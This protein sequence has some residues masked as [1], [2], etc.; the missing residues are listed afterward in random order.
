M[1]NWLGTWITIGMAV[2]LVVG[3]SA[4]ARAGVSGELVVDGKPIKIAT[5]YAYAVKGTFDP[6][7]QDVVV[8]LCD[9]AVP[10]AAQRDADARIKISKEGK[11][12]CVEQTIEADKTVLG[13]AVLHERF[14][15]FLRGS[16]SYHK[17]EA[18]TF[19]GKTVAGHSRTSRPE[20]FGNVPYSYDITFSVPIAPLK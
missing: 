9:V 14:E 7:A 3:P 4:V 8:V 20:S 16:S 18:K 13:F 1:S 5:A 2:A 17:F 10:P 15:P 11:L 19:D 6:K 12:H